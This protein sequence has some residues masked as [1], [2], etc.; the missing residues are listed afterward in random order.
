MLVMSCS[1]HLIQT[2]HHS[3]ILMELVIVVLHHVHLAAHTQHQWHHNISDSIILFNE[4]KE[5]L[6]LLF[7]S[8]VN[9]VCDLTLPF[10]QK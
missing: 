5:Y 3:Y 8:S 4:E 10:L 9:M 6:F 2:V 7:R 1:L